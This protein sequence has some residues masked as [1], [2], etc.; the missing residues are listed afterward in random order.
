MA[1]FVAASETLPNL[2]AAQADA[3]VVLGCKLRADGSPGG[4]LRRRVALGVRLYE[5]GAAPF[6]VMAGGGTPRAEAEA[7]RETAIAAGVPEAALLLEL[8]SRNTAE[9]A[10]YTARVLHRRGLRRIVLVSDRSHL[11]RASLLFRLAG[12]RVIGRAGAP[13]RSPTEALV[14][15]V[16]DAVALPHSILRVLRARRRLR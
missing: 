6:V 15:G 3:I 16:C 10:L 14:S 1:G 5:A 12:L 4:R 7:M 11:F 9:N 2:A 8:C 13:A